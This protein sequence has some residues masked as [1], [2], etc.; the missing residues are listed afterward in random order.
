MVKITLEMP[1]V[2][3]CEAVKCGYN[4]SGSCHAKA[5]TIGDILSPDC[6]T[7][8][9]TTS[10]PKLVTTVAGVGACKVRGCKFNKD[11]ECSGDSIQVGLVGKNIRCLTYQPA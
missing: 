8:L 5:I 3:K 6:D 11:Y 4:K 2:T 9:S 1:Q 7:Y 10:P